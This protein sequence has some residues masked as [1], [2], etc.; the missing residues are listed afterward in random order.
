[1]AEGGG[2]T[3]RSTRDEARRL[4]RRTKL[5]A[6]A[7][8][9]FR[10]RGFAQVSVD[11]IGTAVGFSGPAVYRYFAGK[12][13]L[14]EEVSGSYLVALRDERSRAGYGDD[15]HAS[16]VPALVAAGLRAPD[17]LV[18]YSRQAHQLPHEATARL[19]EM[20]D[21]L[22]REWSSLVPVVGPTTTSA[23]SDGDLRA[24]C[25]AGAITHAALARPGTL[26]LK[27]RLLGDVVGALAAMP[28]SSQ[29]QPVGRSTTEGGPRL[30]HATRREA[31]LAAA[32]E[33][34]SER[35]FVAVSLHDIG[36]RAGITAS[37]V[38]RHFD[39]KE[40]LLSAAV[41]RVGEQISAGLAV[42]LRESRQAS[43]AVGRIV[44]M[45]AQL[46]VDHRDV[47]VIHTTEAASLPEDQ[48][49]ERRRRHRVYVDEL[50][51]VIEQASP[52]R[53]RNE[54]RL[55][56]GMVFALINEAVLSP[57]IARR[58]GVVRDLTR[59]GMVAA[60]GPQGVAPSP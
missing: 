13:E 33:L 17:A 49:A 44:G 37:A 38:M 36:S 9:L 12:Q 50:A 8:E 30:V 15:L 5:V 45:Y 59:M 26:P 29:A 10:Q 34:M 54:C 57:D 42:A 31:V 47:V 4:D 46:A 25:A 55:R 39:S 52:E 27:T 56:A 43:E 35:G 11:D 53:T 18:V 1:M 2:S 58:P 48:R 19:R 6:A 16:A 32:T 28:V 3:G 7:A 51:H 23:E 41:M 20:R 60:S 14:L 22:G 24:R 21:E 40:A